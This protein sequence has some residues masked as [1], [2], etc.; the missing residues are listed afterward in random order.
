[1]TLSCL[2]VHEKLTFHPHRLPPT[3]PPCCESLGLMGCGQTGSLWGLSQVRTTDGAALCM[4][5]PGVFS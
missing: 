2:W 1:M 5:F 4:P 3:S